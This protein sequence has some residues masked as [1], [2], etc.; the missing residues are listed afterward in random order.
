MA[1]MK[2]N[3][4]LRLIKQN[5]L[6]LAVILS[7]I[8]IFSLVI[9][10]GGIQ[11]YEMQTSHEYANVNSLLDST[12]EGIKVSFTHTDHDLLLGQQ[13]RTTCFFGQHYRNPFQI[14]E[15]QSA[16]SNDSYC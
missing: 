3:R 5:K 13:Q 4:L 2:R 14:R 10:F 7:L 15:Q 8:A 16:I 6:F 12:A 11:I 9:F 1:N